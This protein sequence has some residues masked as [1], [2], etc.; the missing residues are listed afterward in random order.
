[1]KPERKREEDPFKTPQYKKL[2]AD[3]KKIIED[4]KAQGVDIGGRDDL[5]TCR[6]C[7]AY[8]DVTYEGRW[9]VKEKGNT[10]TLHERFIIL[11]SKERRTRRH[12]TAYFKTTYTFICPVCGLQQEEI[13]RNQFEDIL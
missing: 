5:L 8:E 2:V 12:N 6:A 4:A 10:P 11:G 3:L 9:I 7:G 13:V 1:M